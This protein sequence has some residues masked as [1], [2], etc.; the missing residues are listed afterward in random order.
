MRPTVPLLPALLAGCLAMLS[1]EIPVAAEGG[2]IR[3]AGSAWVADAPTKVADALGLFN[4]AAGPRIRVDH[5]NSGRDALNSLLNGDSEFA[6]AAST[7]VA[8]ALLDAANENSRA[9]ALTVLALVSSSNR[10]HV[11]IAGGGA[12]ID[13]PADLLGKRVA[14]MLNTAGHFGWRHFTEYHNLDTDKMTLVDLPV[15]AHAEAMASGRI[16][17]AVT[18]EPW[19]A[20][21]RASLDG[22]AQVF[23]TRHLY[24]VGW[25]LVTR[26]DV[27]EQF[28][29]SAD[30][31]LAAYRDAIAEMDRDPQRGRRLHARASPLDLDPATLQTLGAGIVWGLRLDWPVLADLE[32]QLDWFTKRAEWASAVP[33]APYEYLYA[34]PL[35]RVSANSINLPPYFFAERETAE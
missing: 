32:A 24:S 18:W 2:P 23:T 34:E 4:A 16:D 20:R 8:R 19:A 9:G 33:P 29:G 30:R 26:T 27:L 3:I 13:E 31:V 5:Y 7:P 14:L 22:R 17:A 1:P 35:R 11:V 6:L 12:G 10:T 21:L 28:P 15:D 25:L